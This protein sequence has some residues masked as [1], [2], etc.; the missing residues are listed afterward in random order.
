VSFDL[1]IEIFFFFGQPLQLGCDIP[2]LFIDIK[3]L[4]VRLNEQLFDSSNFLAI[5]NVV[6][7]E[8]IID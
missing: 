4:P 3:E 6:A 8:L 1:S 2:D 5:R 7:V